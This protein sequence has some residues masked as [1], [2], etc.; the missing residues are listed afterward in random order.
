MKHLTKSSC[1][2]FA[3]LALLVLFCVPA[4][5]QTI[6]ATVTG[7][8]NDASGAVIPGVTV[9]AVNQGTQA[10]YSGRDQ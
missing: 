3:V 1:A 5:G 7:A 6:T 10:T 9:I 4:L 2:G 8:V